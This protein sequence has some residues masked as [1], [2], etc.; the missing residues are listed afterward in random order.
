MLSCNQVSTFTY[1]TKDFNFAVKSCEE[2]EVPFD[3]ILQEKWKQAEEIKLFR[4]SLNIRSSK[5]LKGR[6][7]F[8]A[9][10]RLLVNTLYA[11]KGKQCLH[12]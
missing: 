3:N 9:Q 11:R 10:V 6:Y 12:R 5:M 4:Y 2:I 1:N 8:L 7:R